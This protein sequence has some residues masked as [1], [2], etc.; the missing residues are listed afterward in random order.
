MKS[1]NLLGDRS[2][3]TTSTFGLADLEAVLE[4]SGDVFEVA[5][6]AGTSGLS[7]HRLL[8]PVDCNTH[9]RVRTSNFLDAVMG[10]PGTSDSKDSKRTLPN[11]GSGVSTARTSA[12]LDVE[13]ATPA[14]TAQCM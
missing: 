9:T 6:A 3:D 8:G 11:F 4:A 5:H 10:E 14:T 7:P 2:L 1:Q 13:R 12:F